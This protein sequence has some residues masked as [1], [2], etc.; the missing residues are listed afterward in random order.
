[1]ECRRNSI[2]IFINDV[3]AV[4]MQGKMKREDVVTFQVFR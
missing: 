3:P 4:D 1:M 2:T